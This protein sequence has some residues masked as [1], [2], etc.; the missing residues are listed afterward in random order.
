M[1]IAMYL[2]GFVVAALG[3]VIAGIYWRQEALLLYPE[4]L[5]PDY[6]FHLPDVVEVPVAVD[7]AVLSALHLRLPDPKGVVFYLHG[8]AGNLASWFAD[9]SL[10]RQS[11]YDL[12][13]LD[14][15]G[16]GK[17]TGRVTSEAQLRSDVAA[18]WQQIAP[19]YKGRCKVFLGRSL[20]SAL[21]A[22]LAARFQ[23]DLTILVSPYWS[24]TELAALHYPFV[25]A[26]LLR[27]RLETFR[28]IAHIDGPVLLIHGD[29]DA[30][31][32]FDHSVRLQ[33]AARAAQLV[34][35]TGAAH[36]DLQ[37]FDDYGKAIAARLAGL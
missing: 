10:F 26:V 28:D 4:P 9:T 3:V 12:F 36:N 32:P 1:R 31:I 13:M 6:V 25:P 35:L 8:N 37:D 19:L 16:Y 18:A 22:G 14:Y 33:A 11:N 29:R 17:S 20:G 15:R 2:I 7:D 27:Y 24:V 21:A 30:V 34:R 5:P 23:P